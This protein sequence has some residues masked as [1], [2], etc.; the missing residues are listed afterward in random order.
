MKKFLYKILYFSIV[1]IFVTI[2]SIFLSICLD[3][4]LSNNLDFF[5]KNNFTIENI[6]QTFFSTEKIKKLFLIIETIIVLIIIYLVM[7]QKSYR[8]N[9]AERK[10]VAKGIKDHVPV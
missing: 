8:S 4:I 7:Q 1:F 5:T 10:E 6:I 3:K 9:V 2:F